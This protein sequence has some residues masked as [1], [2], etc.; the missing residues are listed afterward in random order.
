VSSKLS[1][2][3]KVDMSIRLA[4]CG[5]S[6]TGKTTLA[7]YASR[8]W[9]LPI[10]PVGSRS[11]AKEM[12]FDNPYDVDKTPQLRGEFQTRLVQAKMDWEK[13]HEDFVTDRTTF[14][15]LAYTMMHNFKAVTKDLLDSAI[16]GGQRYTHV[17]LCPMD[18][19]FNVGT[20]P[21][22][23]KDRFYHETFEL[24]AHGLT[25]KYCTKPMVGNIPYRLLTDR[26]WFVRDVLAGRQGA[27]R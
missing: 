27:R 20:D 12:G 11:V 13:E 6:G 15:N 2:T 22:R 17:F 4:F 26:E 9:S 1:L 16:E 5:A 8:L 3:S 7:E 10:N 14:D 23:I 25:R 21:I 24:I 19:F 18:S